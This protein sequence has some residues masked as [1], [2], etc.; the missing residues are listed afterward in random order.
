MP[1][2]LSSRAGAVAR[3]ALTAATLAFAV[4]AAGCGDDDDPTGPGGLQGTFALQ[5]VDGETLPVTLED[6]VGNVIVATGGTLVMADDGDWQMSITGTYNDD[7]EELLSDFGTYELDGDDVTF[8]SDEFFDQFDG[9]LS[10]D[11]DTVT[12]QYDG[13]GDGSPD[14]TFRFVR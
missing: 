10:D 7:P 4:A 3:R 6:D 13:D 9:T 11:D 2:L 14:T 8:D 5:S 12:I 1:T